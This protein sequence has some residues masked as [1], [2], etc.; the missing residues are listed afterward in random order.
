[1]FYSFLAFGTFSYLLFHI[2]ESFFPSFVTRKLYYVAASYLGIIFISFFIILAYELI[3]L[4]FK[5]NIPIINS[6]VV[7]L[8]LLISVFSLINGAKIHTINHEL[9]FDYSAENFTF[10][11]LTDIHLGSIRDQNYLDD[12]V[13]KTIAAK[14]DVVFIT[15]DM[16]D[17]TAPLSDEMLEPFNRLKVPIYFSLGNHEQYEG[18]SKV[19]EV[20]EKTNITILDNKVEHFKG[21]QLIGVDFS[22][23]KTNLE[24]ILPNLKY[25]SSVPTILLSHAP[26]GFTYA[27]SNGV[28]LMLS[29]HTHGG[30]IFPFN[31]LVRLRYKYVEGLHKL[32]NSFLYVNPG[33]GTWGPPMRLGS[34]NEIAV[35]KINFKK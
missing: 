30:Q 28:D 22:E 13:D 3:K 6:L 24:F 23:S 17:G 15:G 7:A 25:N 9:T 18:L 14:P 2:I 19:I 26:D 4:V 10:V 29:G 27:S 31:F 8:I 21:I 34:D 11:H 16:F 20:L 35:F 12:V 1:M 5:F 33:T 32:N